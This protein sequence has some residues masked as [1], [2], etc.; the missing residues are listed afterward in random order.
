MSVTPIPRAEMARRRGRATLAIEL[1]RPLGHGPHH[2][3]IS[4]A[5]AEGAARARDVALAPYHGPS[6]PARSLT[7]LLRVGVIGE[8]RVAGGVVPDIVL[9]RSTL[10]EGW[11]LGA[12]FRRAANRAG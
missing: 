9:A 11:D 2:Q 6:G 1:V 12:S 4:L 5:A 7:E 10:G 8:I 3:L